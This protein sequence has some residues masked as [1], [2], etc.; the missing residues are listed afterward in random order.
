MRI[1]SIIGSHRKNGN[2]ET[3]LKGFDKEFKSAEIPDYK[4]KFF[5]ISEMN[6]YPCRSCLKCKKKDNCV[7]GDDFGKVALKM[8]QSDLIILGS[9][10]YFSDVS[11][12]I[13]GLFDRTYSLWHK[14]MLK[15][16]NIILVATCAEEGTGHTIDSMRH[17][18]I[19]H[20]MNIIATVEGSSEKKGKV[21]DNPMTLKAIQDAVRECDG[22]PQK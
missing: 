15:G 17:W 5:N 9:P 12:Q 2:T 18:A 19:D 6:I 20:E 4:N 10:V 1:V 13:K 11:A 8:I 16:K 21:L 7:I 3:I 14:K 22:I